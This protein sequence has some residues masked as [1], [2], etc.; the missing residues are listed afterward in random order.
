MVEIVFSYIQDYPN[1]ELAWQTLVDEF[2]A[3]HKVKIHLHKML[4]DTAWSELFGYASQVKGP[5]VSHIGNTWVGGLARMNALRPFK[6][7][8]VIASGGA[9]AFIRAN[10]ESGL[11]MED[12]RVWAI[13]WTGWIYAIC[14]R[15]DLL[16]KAGIDPSTAFGTIN[17]LDGTIG[18]LVA[19][20]LEIPW[21]NPEVPVAFRDLLHIAASWIWAAGGDFINYEGTKVLFN[22]PE[23]M[24]GLKEWLDTYRAVPEAFKRLTST[25]TIDLF[26]QGKAAAVLANI[27]SAHSLVGMQ[28]NP[29]V[30]ENLGI[31]S[32]TDVPWT[33]G[34]SLVIWQHVTSSPR[35]QEQAAVDFVKFLGSRSVNVR[36][37]RDVNSMPSRVDA[38]NEIYL[39]G[40]PLRGAVM[41][42]ARNGRGYHSVS[43]WRRVESQLSDELGAVVKE[44]TENPSADPESVLHAHL[45]PLAERLNVT[46]K[47]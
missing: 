25:Q 10:W 43:I 20:N 2:S 33:G 22:S 18:R 7:D 21:L 13:P 14:Y 23:A 6:Q 16:A 41:Q 12:N 35:Q 38:L 24:R 9:P 32:V 46:L 5:H 42:A 1:N 37:H 47:S 15:K 29:E 40:N 11:L 44:V 31:A 19:S 26:R 39:E 28:D 30:R 27:Y 3:Q 34:G 36:Y 4:W 45:D 8:E 17:T